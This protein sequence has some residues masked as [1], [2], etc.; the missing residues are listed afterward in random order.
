[1]LFRSVEEGLPP[2]FGDSKRLT[3][4]LMNLVGNA[5]KFTPGGGSVSVTAK[6]VRSAECGVRSAT[7]TTSHLAPRTSDT[8]DFLE[9]A[10]AD[11]GIGIP[12]EQLQSIF[13]EFHQADSSIT[14]EYGGSGLGLSIAKRFVEL[15][16]GTIWAESQVGQGSVFHVRIPLRTQWEAMA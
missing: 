12:A 9:I 1:M 14:R 15:H 16:L 4:V 2:A 6:C 11:T 10:V 8:G 3:Q 7:D 13:S 5:I